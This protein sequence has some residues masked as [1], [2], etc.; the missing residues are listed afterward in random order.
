VVASPATGEAGGGDEAMIKR[1]ITKLPKWVQSLIAEKDRQL[2]SVVAELSRT[3]AA[4][5]LL[6]NH[7]WFTISGPDFNN[8]EEVR[9]LWFLNREHPLPACSLARGDLLLVGRAIDSDKMK[10]PLDV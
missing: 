3:R 10:F 4:H 9:K 7:D 2:N 1:N 8:G 5:A 6:I